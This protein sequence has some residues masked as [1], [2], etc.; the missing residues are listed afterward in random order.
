MQW[1]NAYKTVVMGPSGSSGGDVVLAVDSVAEYGGVDSSA[2][3]CDG[4]SLLIFPN[5]LPECL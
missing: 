1:E 3:T 5:G 2:L 4:M